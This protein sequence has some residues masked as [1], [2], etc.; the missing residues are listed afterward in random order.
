MAG[1]PPR[2]TP[3]PVDEEQEETLFSRPPIPKSSAREPFSESGVRSTCVV[4]KKNFSA[5][6]TFRLLRSP[7]GLFRVGQ[8]HSISTYDHASPMFSERSFHRG[9]APL[10]F[11]RSWGG[12]SRPLL[13]WVSK[14]GVGG[15]RKVLISQGLLPLLQVT[16]HLLERNCISLKHCAWSGESANT[17]GGLIIHCCDLGPSCFFQHSVLLSQDHF[18]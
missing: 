17:C 18:P 14:L 15:Q 7:V 12:S 2:E 10:P 5:F 13:L 11:Q 4:P 3:W 6:F 16:P 9:E 1:S 8:F